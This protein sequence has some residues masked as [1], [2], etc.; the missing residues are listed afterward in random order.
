MKSK[1]EESRSINQFGK[2]KKL[3]EKCK[4]LESTEKSNDQ[5]YKF[6]IT[7]LDWN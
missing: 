2:D 3:E 4:E 5:K 7:S 6:E 1:L